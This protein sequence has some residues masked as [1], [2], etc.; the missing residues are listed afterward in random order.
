MKR[1]MKVILAVMCIFPTILMGCGNSSGK[2]ASEG[3]TTVSEST[4]NTNDETKNLP[5]VTIEVENFGT[6]EAELYPEVAPNTVNNFISLADS[7]FYNNLTFHRVIKNFMIQGGDPSGNGTGGPGY[8]IKGEFTSN[9]FANS[10]KHSEGVLSMA[11]KQNDMNSAGSQFFIMTK[12]NEDLDGEYAA[13]GKVISGMDVVKK[14]S[15]VKTGKNDK[16][17]EDVV[18]KSISVDTKGVDYQEPDIIK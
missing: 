18:I 5:I 15:E 11:R 8:G 4:E 16:P 7:G 13:F 14:I 6:I 9:G 17:N 2:T 10:L 1:F 3:K 12:D